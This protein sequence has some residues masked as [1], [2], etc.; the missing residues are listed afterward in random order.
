MS[1]RVKTCLII[2]LAFIASTLVAFFIADH[3]VLQKFIALEEASFEEDNKKI[4]QSLNALRM[5]LESIAGDWA[6][7]DATYNFLQGN[8]TSFIKNNLMNETFE[9]LHLNIF[10]LFDREGKLAYSTL[11]DLKK[12]QKTPLRDGRVQEIQHMLSTLDVG[13][14]GKT[15]G[16]F[17][18][19]EHMIL[20]VAPVLKS[21]YSGPPMGTLV[22]GEF[23]GEERL[24]NIGSLLGLSLRIEPI[25]KKMSS[26]HRNWETVLL[27]KTNARVEGKILIP[28]ITGAPLFCLTASKPR[29][30]FQSGKMTVRIILLWFTIAQ[31]AIAMLLLLL[32]HTTILFRLQSMA[33][34][35]QNISETADLHLRLDDQGEDEIGFFSQNINSML[36]NIHKLID[37]APDLFF[38]CNYEGNIVLAN[39]LAHHTLGYESNMLV[40]QPL[41]SFMGIAHFPL[42][43]PRE[44]I[45]TKKNGEKLPVEMY[46]QKLILGNNHLIL[47]IARDISKRKNLQNKLYHMAYR[48]SLT[49][50]PNRASFMEKLYR[51]IEG[52]KRGKRVP[53]LFVMLDVDNFKSVNDTFGHLN[54]DRV[55]REVGKRV[56]KLLRS[57]DILARLGGDEFALLL[58][59]RSWEE[60]VAFGNAVKN[61]MEPPFKV[62]KTE[63]NL[64]CSI[65][66][67]A[68]SFQYHSINTLFQDGDKAL[69]RAKRR[70]G[71]QT[72]IFEEGKEEKPAPEDRTMEQDFFD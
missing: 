33:K 12:V 45:L 29:L 60:G 68:H 18:T 14:D 48:D 13:K 62:G 38:L 4:L 6:P 15:T 30:L 71:K 1:I 23:F 49:G 61:S 65:G 8:N 55:L 26:S 72:V 42:L 53:F 63:R 10:L 70:G 54:G 41:S 20:A 67:V 50:L 17:S 24:Q 56:S 51:M 36:E 27:G 25:D 52:N 34:Q 69:Y 40:N 57:Q 58:P 19:G 22:V 2:L 59:G 32:F 44:T 46:V 5:R 9:N 16:F 11:F 66:I 28:D 43:A 47:A 31:G 64:S 21:D 7:W 37:K 39:E 35:I 3:V